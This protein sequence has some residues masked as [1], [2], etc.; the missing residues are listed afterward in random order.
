MP[1]INGAH[2]LV[3]Q[4]GLSKLWIINTLQLGRKKTNKP[5]NNKTTPKTRQKTQT[6]Q[7]KQTQEGTG[8]TTHEVSCKVLVT[9]T[10]E[11]W[12]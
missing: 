9:N 6:P 10:P 11:K 1:P 4:L 12:K 8:T 7:T 2:H 3:V 5:N